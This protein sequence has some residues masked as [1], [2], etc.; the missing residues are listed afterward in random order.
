MLTTGLPAGPSTSTIAAV[1]QALGTERFESETLRFLH[2]TSGVEHY[3][4]YRVRGDKPEFIAGASIRGRH[5]VS[6][7]RD[8]PRERQRSYSDLQAASEALNEADGAVIV[9]DDLET[10]DDV[11]LRRALAHFHI[12]D[13]VVVCGRSCEDIYAVSLLRSAE[14]GPFDDVELDRLNGAAEV[15]IAAIARHAAIDGDKPRASAGFGSVESIEARL[16]NAQWKLTERELQVAARILFG[17]L[18]VGI[19][20]DLGLGE[21]TVATYRKRL[22]RRL[23]IGS[24][25]EL[26]QR[27]LTLL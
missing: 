10:L 3:T 18:T 13:R 4:V 23:R 21:E 11:A 8:Q 27:Y 7:D 20:L 25:H 5:A 15:L 16:R 24:R 14:T 26:F 1:I 2:S 6:T 22:Y 9:H 12:V 19:S 17:V